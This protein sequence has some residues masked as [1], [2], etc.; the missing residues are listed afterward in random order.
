MN[1]NSNNPQSQDVFSAAKPLGLLI[2]R[3]NDKAGNAAPYKPPPNLKPV[4]ME[5]GN[6]I[7]RLPNFPKKFWCRVWSEE[8]PDNAGVWVKPGQSQNHKFINTGWT[9]DFL[10]HALAFKFDPAPTRIDRLPRDRE[11]R[12]IISRSDVLG[13]K[14]GLVVP[15]PTI[16]IT[17]ILDREPPRWDFIYMLKNPVV[18]SRN[19]KTDKPIEFLHDLV[20]RFERKF[21]C[22]AIGKWDYHYNFYQHDLDLARLE[23][24][25][26]LWKLNEFNES[27]KPFPFLDAV[28]LTRNDQICQDYKMGM[29]VEA[30]ARKNKLK[31]RRVQ[32][33][34]K[35]HGIELRPSIASQWR[36]IKEMRARPMK[37]YEIANHF[38][39]D[40][41]T[42]SRIL[43]A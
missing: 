12:P 1:N 33:I 11:G 37:V 29:E 39:C 10:I 23:I 7:P 17:S 14:H 2:D 36:E 9:P 34:L 25:G 30:I 41:R 38:D 18:I 6:G 35:E 8:N 32:V 19:R 5:I 3:V 43:N 27:I 15:K 31:P 26:E 20:S 16:A 4:Q 13:L 42:I 24:P 21:G 22:R 28:R 40:V